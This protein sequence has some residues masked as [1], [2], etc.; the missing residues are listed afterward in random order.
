MT[1]EASIPLFRVEGSGLGVL[2]DEVQAPVRVAVGVGAVVLVVV[3][4]VVVA[5]VVVAVVV[6][7]GDCNSSRRRRRSSRS[8]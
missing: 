7:S 3:F 8:R 5:K 1:L 2:S 4:V 6:V